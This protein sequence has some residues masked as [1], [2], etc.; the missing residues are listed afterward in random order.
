[1]PT[2][3]T[4]EIDDFEA[5]IA[6]RKAGKI[7]EKVFAETRLRRGAYGQRYTHLL[8]TAPDGQKEWERLAQDVPNLRLSRS[9]TSRAARN[10]EQDGVDYNFISRARFEQMVA[11]LADGSI[12]PNDEKRR[13]ARAV[14]DLLV[15][16]GIVAEPARRH[17]RIARTGVVVDLRDAGDP[18]EIAARYDGEGAD[19]VCFL[20]ITASSDERD[21][22]LHVIEAVAERV[23]IPLTV[24]GGVRQVN[25]VPRL[26]KPRARKI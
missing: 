24:G 2:S 26:I 25:D 8:R 20:D 21:L 11:G 19:E 22:L 10:G 18:V 6:L 7:E 12:H 13:M 14:V 23:F 9:Y 5:Q 3:L 17:L 4:R 15:G 16:S 1:M